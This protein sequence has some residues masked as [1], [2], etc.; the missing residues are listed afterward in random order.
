MFIIDAI[1]P[2]TLDQYTE[3]E[4]KNALAEKEKRRI[5]KEGRIAIVKQ[6]ASDLMAKGTEISAIE[7]VTS[8]GVSFTF[9]APDGTKGAAMFW[10]NKDKL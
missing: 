1:V 8:S 6:L 10:F 4:L 3:A 7:S 2:R 9:V 5:A